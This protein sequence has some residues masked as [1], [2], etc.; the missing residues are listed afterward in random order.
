MGGIFTS[1]LSV[2]RAEREGLFVWSC[3]EQCMGS[4][5]D[6]NLLFFKSQGSTKYD[7]ASSR[8]T[9]QEAFDRPRREHVND[10][11][12]LSTF[13]SIPKH[14]AVT[15]DATFSLDRSPLLVHSQDDIER[16][17]KKEERFFHDRLDHYPFHQCI[18]ALFDSR[19]NSAWLLP[20]HTRIASQCGI[21]SAPREM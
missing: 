21:V 3:T 5:C 4:T 19:G 13:D 2:G 6:K 7:V 10:K 9:P 15:R 14:P 1:W 8:K 11:T 20:K 18:C 17:G 16:V 12:P